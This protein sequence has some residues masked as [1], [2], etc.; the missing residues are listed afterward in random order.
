MCNFNILPSFRWAVAES[1]TF[2]TEDGTEF[3]SE[4]APVLNDFYFLTDP[5]KFITKCFPDDPQWQLQRKHITQTEFEA[6]PFL[7]PA[8]YELRLKTKSHDECVIY[9]EHGK[10]DLTIE[11]P[12]D[13]TNSYKFHYKLHVQRDWEAEGEYNAILLDKYLLYYHEENIAHFEIR[14]PLRGVYKLEIHCNDPRNPIPSTWVCDYKIICKTPMDFCNPLPVV[15]SIGWGVGDEVNN[16][17]LECL[18][19]KDTKV[20]L[21][22]ETVTFVRFAL[23]KDKEISLEAELLHNDKSASELESHVVT[24]QDGEHATFQISPPS[25]GE[26]ALRVYAKPKSGEKRENVCNFLMYRTKIIEVG[27]GLS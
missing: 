18:T 1:D 24:D 8:F 16:A 4:S 11:I 27:Q 19:H 3:K 2:H 13:K 26:Y 15:P 17:G 12:K 23:P 7:Q 5:D 6:L 20:S 14:F 25:E 9:T 21:D 10:V 22:K